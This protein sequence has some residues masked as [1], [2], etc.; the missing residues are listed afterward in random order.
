MPELYERLMGTNTDGRQ[1]LPVHQFMALVAEQQRGNANP[2]G[3]RTTAQH[4]IDAFGLSSVEQTEV[5]DLIAAFNRG[6][7]PITADQLHN[8]LL[9]AEHRLGVFTSAATVRTRLG[10]PTR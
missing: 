8:A 1:K 9:A 3:A 10:V 7:A 4:V 5:T 2:A 6:T